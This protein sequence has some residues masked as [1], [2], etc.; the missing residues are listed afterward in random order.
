MMLFVVEVKWNTRNYGL[1]TAARVSE[2]T[3]SRIV[4]SSLSEQR[5]IFQALDL[6]KVI[7]GS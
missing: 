4:T 5:L 7:G 6:I 2:K 1:E 3:Q